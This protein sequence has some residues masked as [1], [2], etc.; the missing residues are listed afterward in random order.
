VTLSGTLAADVVEFLANILT[1]IGFALAVLGAFAA[2]FALY[3]DNSR[4]RRTRA[5]D[6]VSATAGNGDHRIVLDEMRLLLEPYLL[7]AHESRNGARCLSLYVPQYIEIDLP[8]QYSRRIGS[9]LNYYEII[10]MGVTNGDLDKNVVRAT[11]RVYLDATRSILP[12][13]KSNY[14]NPRQLLISTS[15]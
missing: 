8:E 15:F 2:L 11:M 7:E 13:M 6:L 12:Q 14:D 3:S 1:V 5:Y 4:E 10:A 9:L